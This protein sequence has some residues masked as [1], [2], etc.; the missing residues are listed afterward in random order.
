MRKQARIV[1]ALALGALAAAGPVEPARAQPF[2]GGGGG[3]P[4]LAGVVGKPLP[5]RGMPTGTVSVRVARKTPANAVVDV[6]VQAIIKNAGG[7]MRRRTAKTDSGGRALFEGLVPGEA[8]HAEVKVDG[9][10]LATDT[11]SMPPVGGVRTMLIS[12]LASTPGRAENEPAGEQ[13]GAAGGEQ[14][15]ESDAQRFSLGATAGKVVPDAALPDK[16]LDLRLFD[17]GGAPIPNHPVQLGMVDTRN[18]VVVIRGKSDATGVARFANLATGKSTGY[19]A[20]MDW[21]GMRLGTAPFAMPD[22]GGSHGEIRAMARTADP[23]VVTIGAGGRVVFQMREDHLQV[24]EFLPLENTSE[25]MFDPSPGALEIPLPKEFVNAEPQ[26]SERKIDVRANHGVAVHGPIVPRGAIIGGGSDA[27]KNAGQEVVFGFE[28]P[29]H[30]DTR[31]LEQA[32]PNG[33]GPFTLIIEQAQGRDITVEGSGVGKRE[34]RPLG[35]HTYWV[36]PVAAVSPGGT[37]E[38]T[39]HGLPSTDSSGRNIAGGLALALIAGAIAFA[40][41]PKR[42]ARG[43]AGAKG[44]TVEQERAEL[45]AA[46][47][48]LYADLVAMERERTGTGAGSPAQ[49][50]TDRRKQLVTRLEQTYRDLAALDERTAA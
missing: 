15:G 50:A 24:L 13:S 34:S 41:P 43:P 9:E 11:F 33:I 30:G 22:H 39:L 4:N 20:V 18:Q 10:T 1:V 26:E 14:A 27:A 23:S 49:A 38:L 31:T 17:E 7:D 35:G 48:R 6:E 42:L 12:G 47:E 28:L 36:M 32:M 45:I 37:L 46:R 25:K 5:D 19:A 44:R 8:F 2:A 40:R 3:M 16:T 29:Y 21:H